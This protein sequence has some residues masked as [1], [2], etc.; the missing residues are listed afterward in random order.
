RRLPAF[1]DRPDDE[2]LA[3]AHVAGRPEL[4]DRRP[5]VVVVGDDVG[6]ATFVRVHLQPLAEIAEDSARERPAETDGDKDEVGLDDE[7]RA[8]DRL[9]A[10]VDLAALDTRQDT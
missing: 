9:A 6:G 4:V 3:A 10:V 7:F 1:A 2:R 8:G 5:V